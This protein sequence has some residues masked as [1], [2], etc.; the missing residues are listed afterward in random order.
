MLLLYLC[1]TLTG[2]TPLRSGLIHYHH[3]SQLH[4]SPI[5]PNPIDFLTSHTPS[6]DGQILSKIEESLTSV[7]KVSVKEASNQISIPE[8]HFHASGTASSQKVLLT[9]KANLTGLPLYAIV[10]LP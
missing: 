3:L 2:Q 5:Q 4:P 10:I 6:S 1:L 7:S 9:E 8:H